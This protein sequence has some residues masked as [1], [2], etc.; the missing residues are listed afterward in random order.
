MQFKVPQN[1]DMEDPLTVAYWARD[2]ILYAQ[3]TIYGA[4]LIAVERLVR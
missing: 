1:I 3:C 2:S 4:R